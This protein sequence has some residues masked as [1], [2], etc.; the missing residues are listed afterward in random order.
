MSSGNLDKC[1]SLRNL[2]E[3]EGHLEITPELL[4]ELMD[5]TN[6]LLTLVNDL[7]PVK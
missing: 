1:H 6:E 2:A 3:Y 5:T 7:G 4:Q